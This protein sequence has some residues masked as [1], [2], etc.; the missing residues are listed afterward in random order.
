MFVYIIYWED[1]SIGPLWRERERRVSIVRQI[2]TVWSYDRLYG[3]IVLSDCAVRLSSEQ[4]AVKYT[5][6]YT[7]EEVVV[8]KSDYHQEEDVR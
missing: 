8:E 6:E 4:W 3:Q 5:G 2:D 7:G 1:Q